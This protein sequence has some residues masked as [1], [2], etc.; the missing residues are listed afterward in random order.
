MN[1][2][3]IGY[4]DV[5]D[6]KPMPKGISKAQQQF[7]DMNDLNVILKNRHPSTIPYQPIESMM[8]DNLFDPENLLQ[9]TESLQSLQE[10]FEK[11][12]SDLRHKF[13]ND[14]LK[15]LAFL[16]DKNNRPQAELWGLVK[17]VPLKSDPEPKPEPLPAPQ[18]KP[19]A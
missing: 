8:N 11:I 1:N 9:A 3:C 6:Q 19:P 12:P 10:N 16:G 14:P 17:P 2:R 18:P 4:F 13:G 5:V 15:M 7:R